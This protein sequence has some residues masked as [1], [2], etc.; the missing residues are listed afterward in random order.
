[1]S[2]GKLLATLSGLSRFYTVAFT[3]DG[4]TLVAGG[5]GGGRGDPE[6]EHGRIMVWELG[7]LE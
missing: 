6:P 3:S 4:I 7:T 1:M 5:G 2:T